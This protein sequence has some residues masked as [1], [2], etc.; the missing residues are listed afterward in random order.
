MKT[1]YVWRDISLTLLACTLF[2][3]CAVEGDD[4]D[5][6]IIGAEA[7]LLGGERQ[8]SLKDQYI[9]VFREGISQSVIA[10]AVNRIE[11]RG[12]GSYI[13]HSFAVVPGFAARLSP[14]ALAELRQRP[15]VLYVEQDR[16]VAVDSVREAGADGLDRVDQRLLPRDGL[17]DD[18]GYDGSGVSVYIID[19]GIRTTHREFIGRIG[20]VIDFVGDGR[21]GQDCD[22]HG[23]Q[24]ASIAAGRTL[25]L[26]KGATVHAVRV[27]DCQG[28]G[29]LSTVMAGIDFVHGSCQ[30]NSD[31]CVA[32][33]SLGGGSSQSIN[34]AVANAVQS[35]VVVAVAAGNENADACERSPANEPLAITVGAVD[36]FDNRASFSNFGS[37]I[38]IFAPGVSIRGADIRSD[39]DVQ[40]IS[41]TSMATPHVTG[42]IAQYLSAY[43]DA[44]PDTVAAALKKSATPGCVT[45]TGGAPNLL[46]FSDLSTSGQGLGCG[47]S[48]SDAA[49]AVAAGA[50]PTSCEGF[51]GEQAPSGCFCDLACRRLGDCCTDIVDICGQ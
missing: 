21:N 27:V 48:D 11:W 32:N 10:A 18:R 35:G 12:D 50:D 44:D 45:G 9:V 26:A 4:I 41:G 40:S 39:N 29:R 17:Y 43:P 22:G 51:C 37:C 13:E 19:T 24:V 14:A 2:G 42:A 7:P 8:D 20:S 36:D 25:G 16:V 46:L 33:V 31:P 3:A 28:L 23:T 6:V 30:R 47:M 15:D 49:A 38:D 34:D 5:S 1:Q